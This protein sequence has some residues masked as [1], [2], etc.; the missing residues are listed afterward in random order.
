M[1]KFI[2]IALKKTDWLIFT[3]YQL[4][5]VIFYV[6]RFENC[7][8]CM[9]IFFVKLNCLCTWLYMIS[10]I[11]ISLHADLFHP[12]IEPKQILPRSVR[13]NLEEMAMIEYG[14]FPRYSEL[15]SQHQMH[16]SFI[17]RKHL[18]CGG[19]VLVPCKE[20]SWSIKSLTDKMFVCL[21]KYQVNCENHLV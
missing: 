16:F 10:S 9:F 19:G 14:S 6:S 8:H 2:Y 18:F 5:C 17:S 20:Y 12:Y 21:R 3:A 1:G 11:I 7:V 13:I 15:E 4:V